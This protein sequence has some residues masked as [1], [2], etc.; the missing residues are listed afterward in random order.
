MTLIGSRSCWQRLRFVMMQSL[1]VAVLVVFN[2]S[3]LS[4]YIFC[5]FRLEPHWKC[6]ILIYFFNMHLQR[7]GV[8]RQELAKLK[9]Q[10]AS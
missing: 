2:F 3:Q 4:T 10:T 5:G 7:G 1:Y 9:K 6:P 8:I